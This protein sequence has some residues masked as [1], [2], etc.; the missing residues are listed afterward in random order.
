MLLPV[1][2]G[3]LRVDGPVRF[4]FRPPLF[5]RPVAARVGRVSPAIAI[6]ARRD[7]GPGR[8][9]RG[10]P[11]A[12]SRRP[13][14][15]ARRPPD[16]RRACAARSPRGPPAA[17]RGGCAGCRLTRSAGVSPDSESLLIAASPAPPRR[18]DPRSGASGRHPRMRSVEARA[19]PS[20]HTPASYRRHA[21]KSRKGSSTLRRIAA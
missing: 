1:T 17:W 19:C 6:S 5:R 8:T 10:C 9:S 15:R 2:G 4:P 11:R 3:V 14:R 18:S 16:R 12:E 13:D 20:C 7:R 21:Y